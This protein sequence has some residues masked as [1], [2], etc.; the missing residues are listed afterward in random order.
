ME[1]LI[2]KLNQEVAEL[3]EKVH[4][5]Q[6]FISS[7]Q[8]DFVSSAQKGLLLFQLRVMGTYFEI[9]NQRI[10]E[11]NSNVPEQTGEKLRYTNGTLQ[12]DNNYDFSTTND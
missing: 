1:T 5:L 9:L 2:E 10:V 12:K 7:E 6:K 3:N 11:I 8:W 4:K